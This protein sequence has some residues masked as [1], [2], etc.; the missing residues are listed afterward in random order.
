MFGEQTDVLN[1]ARVALAILAASAGVRTTVGTHGSRTGFIR[2]APRTGTIDLNVQESADDGEIFQEHGLLERVGKIHVVRK[3]CEKREN[4]ER[5]CG[6][7]RVEAHEKQDRTAELDDDRKNCEEGGH[8][9]PG[10]SDVGDCS[11][12]TGELAP[13][14][15]QKHQRE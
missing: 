13:S 6:D 8:G 1:L 12:K 15:D 9:K 10:G 4:R 5:E 7:P 11:L 14:D 2:D 3:S